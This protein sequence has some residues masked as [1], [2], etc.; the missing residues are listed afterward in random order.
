MQRD[1]RCTTHSLNRQTRRTATAPARSLA[2]TRKAPPAKGGHSTGDGGRP[3]AWRPVRRRACLPSKHTRGSV[4]LARASTT[5]NADDLDGQTEEEQDCQAHLQQLK[6]MPNC[7][8]EQTAEVEER[9]QGQ[10]PQKP[11]FIGGQLAQSSPH[12]LEPVLALPHQ[13]W[14]HDDQNDN[15]NGKQLEGSDPQ[16]TARDDQQ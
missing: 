16:Q 13:S 8:Q 10:E 2:G 15:R 7:L 3:R 9:T 11:A 6:W 12:E 5:E 14:A 1:R 4:N